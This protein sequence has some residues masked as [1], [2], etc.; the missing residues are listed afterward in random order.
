M[1]E[2]T[3]TSKEIRLWGWVWSLRIGSVFTGNNLFLLRV[4]WTKA[5]TKYSLPR[6]RAGRT[7]HC[8]K[9]ALRSWT[10][11]VIPHKWTPQLVE[12]KMKD[13]KGTFSHL[14]VDHCLWPLCHFSHWIV[15]L[16]VMRGLV[17]GELLF[18]GLVWAKLS[19]LSVATGQSMLKRNSWTGVIYKDL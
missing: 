19:A 18:D 4:Q 15:F 8:G 14:P 10:W 17:I 7:L 9:Q 6:N 11:F 12:N 2:S 1:K 16:G 13:D 5:K 3:P